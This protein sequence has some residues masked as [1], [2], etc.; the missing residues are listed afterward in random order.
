TKVGE[1]TLTLRGAN[2][3]SGGTT[4][5]GGTLKVQD[6][7]GSGT[8]TGAVDVLS[9]SLAGSGVIT[10]AVTVGTGSGAGAFL[11]PGMGASKATTLTIQSAVNFKADGPYIC[12]LNT[13]K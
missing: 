5:D 7:V 3:Y 2:T 4:M 11:T 1:G 8:G 10:G 9:G 13:K 6:T 12:R